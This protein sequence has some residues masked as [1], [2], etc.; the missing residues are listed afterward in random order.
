MGSEDIH[1]PVLQ[2]ATMANSQH[3]SLMLPDYLIDS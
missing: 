2:F 1:V 3:V